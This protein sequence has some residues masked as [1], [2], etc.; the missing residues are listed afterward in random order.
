[1][2]DA[3][4]LK[5][6]I[7]DDNRSAADALVRVLRKGGDEV[8]AVYDGQTAIDAIRASSPDLVLTDLK[9][10]PVDGLAVLRAARELRPP[11][12]VIVFTAFG[13]VDVAV[14]AMRLGARDFLTKPVTVEQVAQ[15]IEQVRQE[16]GPEPTMPPPEVPFIAE[17][18]RSKELLDSLRK[19]AGV[20]SPVW[21]EGEIG[22]GRGHAAWALH[23]LGPM[24][25]APYTVRDLG[26]DVPWPEAG[27]VVL[28]SVDDLPDDLQRHLHRSLAHVP[29][30]VRLIATAT[31]NGRHLVTEGKLRAELYYALAVIVVHVPPLRARAEDVLPLLDLALDGLSKRYGRPKPPIEPSRAR[32]LM[33]H[34]W[35]GNVR[36][37][38]NIAE[39]AV[40]MGP[41]A[42]DIEAVEAPSEGMPKL[43][44]G[45]DLAAYLEGV[46]RK[47]L[48]EAL[49][50]SQGDRNR[51]GRLLGVERNTLRYKLNKY[52]L[53]DQ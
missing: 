11:V 36:E 33:K 10:E 45:F 24:P 52:G 49:R 29:P 19:A 46:E 12:D 41:T 25:D 26:R 39:R 37:L 4:S 18:A 21:I 22:S 8:H 27:T 38:L 42:F 50:K 53:L 40:V 47:I 2:D 23:Q 7:V 34:T 16:R 20:P 6:L 48:V 15:R 3:R 17:S 51:A 44:P 9:M 28:P 13:A 14:K 30:L 43:E 32:N 5:L 35:P 1:V 31:S